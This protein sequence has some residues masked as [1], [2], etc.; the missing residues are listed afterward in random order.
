MSI[1]V[2]WHDKEPNV[3]LFK[4]ETPWD[5]AQL[6]KAINLARKM[7]RA[8]HGD[9]YS[10]VYSDGSEFGLPRSLRPSIM[11]ALMQDQS[12]RAFKKSFIVAPKHVHY[13]FDML[14]KICPD[15]REFLN[16]VDTWEEGIAS[17]QKAKL[18]QEPLSNPVIE[19]K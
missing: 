10:I 7:A 8:V 12:P 14:L 16:L 9:V 3:I 13:F 18:R 15:L 6:E 5:I 2:T 11:A 19:Y 4:L 1:S 17:I